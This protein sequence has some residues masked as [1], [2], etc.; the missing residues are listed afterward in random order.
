MR[1]LHGNGGKGYEA[2]TRVVRENGYKR[3]DYVEWV[4]G[5]REWV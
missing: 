3:Y 2:Y 4:W 1:C 5:C